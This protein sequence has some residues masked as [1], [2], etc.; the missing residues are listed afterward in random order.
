LLDLHPRGGMVDQDETAVS[1]K[2][3][4]AEGNSLSTS[5]ARLDSSSLAGETSA[6]LA[7]AIELTAPCCMSVDSALLCLSFG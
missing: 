7:T 3:V 5:V 6:S 1:S 2:T 4:T